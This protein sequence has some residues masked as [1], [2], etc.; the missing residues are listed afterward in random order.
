MADDVEQIKRFNAYHRILHV[1][2]AVSFIGLVAS[3]MP[4][5]Y[6]QAPWASR[7]L[8]VMGGYQGAALVHRICAVITFGYFAAHIGYVIYDVAMVRKFKFN[9]LGPESMVPWLKDIEDMYYNFKWFLGKGPRPKFD[10]WAYWEKFDYWAVFWGVG[11]IGVSGLFLWFPEFFG[12]FV[13]GWVFNV[14]TVIHSDEAL[15]AAGFIFTIH[16]FNTHLRP[17]KFP[18]DTVIFTGR[19]TLHDLQQERPLEYE[20]LVEQ[21]QLERYLVE[22]QK[23][24]ITDVG[25]AFG[26]SAVLIGFLL[27]V[28]IILGQFVY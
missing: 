5:K 11:M 1:V 2:M 18:M 27:L 3:G 21:K 10:R 13:P 4:I 14:A 19:V 6:A 12:S 9:P 23:N 25:I 24:W 15:L 16:Y 22:P 7:L 28:L 17:E 8:N 20:R 26:F